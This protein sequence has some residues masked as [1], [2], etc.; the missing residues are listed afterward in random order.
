MSSSII[1]VEMVGVSRFASL[2][3]LEWLDRGN[4]M[5]ESIVFV[6]LSAPISPKFLLK[7]VFVDPFLSN[8]V[9]PVKWNEIPGF[10]NAESAYSPSLLKRWNLFKLRRKS[11]NSFE[12]I[13]KQQIVTSN[14][15]LCILNR[16]HTNVKENMWFRH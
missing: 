3:L 2:Q 9:F 10:S 5:Y 11:S 6:P 1:K 16:K 15:S 12:M 4:S 7:L 13:W 14:E 8:A